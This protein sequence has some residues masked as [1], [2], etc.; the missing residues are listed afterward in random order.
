METDIGERSEKME[1]H[2]ESVHGWSSFLW[3]FT[4]R[5][6]Y[7]DRGEIA[8]FFQFD[9]TKDGWYSYHCV[10]NAVDGSILDAYRLTLAHD[11][12]DASVVYYEH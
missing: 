9:D 8:F 1:L 11:S 12:E 4:D 6:E 10:V 5:K 3:E 7:K 2:I